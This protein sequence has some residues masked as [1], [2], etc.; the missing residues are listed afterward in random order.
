MDSTE[1]GQ[2]QFRVFLS[3][4]RADRSV[5]EDV[6]GVLEARGLKVLWDRDINAGHPF[7]DSIRS[8]IANSHIFMPLITLQS[9]D[10]PWLHREEGYAL[11][12]NI[13]IVPLMIGSNHAKSGSILLTENLQAIQVAD[14]CSDLEERLIATDFERVVFSA[15]PR[16]RAML[17]EIAQWQETRAELMGKHADRVLAMGVCGTV[18]QRGALSSFCIPD[19]DVRHI[20]WDRREG[21]RK[22][23]SY[24]RDLQKRERQALER[25]ARRGGAK[26][27][28]DPWIT[29]ARASTDP[30]KAR[31]ESLLEFLESVDD[32]QAQVIT[33]RG[34][35]EGNLTIVGDWFVA[36]SQIPRPGDGYR[37][38]VFTWHAPTVLGAVRDFDSAFASICRDQNIDP[39]KSRTHTIDVVKQRLREL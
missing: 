25:H 38:T 9:H 32:K 30:V 7:S 2:Y 3:Y 18:R 26:L 34:E 15:E 17:V 20:L 29:F 36:E 8:F 10:R 19:R 6:V 22:R 11:A 39:S 13:P 35:N 33:R 5:A 24:L 23:S 27:I 12:L 14:D 1:S 16:T 21:E 31:L 28:I 4:A 37:Q